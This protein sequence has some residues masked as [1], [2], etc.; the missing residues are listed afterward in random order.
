MANDLPKPHTS[1]GTQQDATAGLP[2]TA[3][4]IQNSEEKKGAVPAATYKDALAQHEIN[5][6]TLQN[7]ALNGT[8][9]AKELG[10]SQGK[11]PN[12]GSNLHSHANQHSNLSN[13]KHSQESKAESSLEEDAKIGQGQGKGSDPQ[14]LP[15]NR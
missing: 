14:S 13:N 3:T 7:L 12:A 11:P 6:Q 4:I 5:Q 10:G 15:P 9:E 8:S 1:D 2:A